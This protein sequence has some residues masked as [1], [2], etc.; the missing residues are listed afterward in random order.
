MSGGRLGE[1]KG[2]GERRREKKRR[3]KEGEGDNAV[4]VR[5]RRGEA[6]HATPRE[7]WGKRRNHARV[8]LSPLPFCLCA[9]P[10]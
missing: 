10:D 4:C 8:A 7:R 6:T 3:G 9:V 1:G 2:G 5:A